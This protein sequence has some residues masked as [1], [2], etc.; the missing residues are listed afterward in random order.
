M[1]FLSLFFSASLLASLAISAVSAN[2]WTQW[3][4]QN[5]NSTTNESSL[6]FDWKTQPPKQLWKV[7]IGQSYSTVAVQ[8][9]RLFTMGNADGKDT[10][11][12]LDVE[13]GKPIWTRSD[14]HAKRE[15]QADPFPKATTATPVVDENRVYTLTREGLALCLDTKTGTVI[16]KKQ[17][18]KDLGAG[19]KSPP[20]GFAGSALI[21]GD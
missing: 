3:R 18:L 8:G 15:S 1:K 6:N 10:I 7:N 14:A 20:F 12:C 2:D 5:R 13:T 17:F 9:N 21:V 16:W 4:G 19:I 11:Y